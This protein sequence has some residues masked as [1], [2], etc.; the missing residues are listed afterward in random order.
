MSLGLCWLRRDL[1]LSDHRALHKASSNFDAFVVV[2]V[3]DTQIL[4]QLEN[5]QDK[6]VAFIVESLKEVD[7]TLRRQG[8]RLVVLHGDPAEE[9]PKLAKELNVQGVVAARDFE[10]YALMRDEL[11][12]ARL[13][14]QG[15]GF[16]T[17][18][19]QVI[20]E[21]GEVLTQSES[22]FRVFTPYSRRWL[23]RFDLQ[24]DTIDYAPNLN[25][26]A[27]V[28]DV[29]I[30]LDY[31]KI[32]FEYCEPWIEPGEKAGHRL[33]QEFREKIDHYGEARDFPSIE[34]GSFLSVHFR[35]GTISIREAVRMAAEHQSPGAK[36]WLTELIWREFY[37]DVLAN[38]PQVVETTFDPQY[39]KLEWQGLDEHFELWKQGQTGYP[40]IDAA[41]RCFAQTGWM[42][43][44]LRMIVA[45]FLTKDLL[46]DYRK[47]ESYF[48]AHLL[49]FDLASNNGGW[50][51]AASV[52]CDAQPYFRIFNPYS[53][54]QKFDADGTFIRQ[55]IPELADLDSKSIHCPT[56]FQVLECGYVEP[57]VEHDTQRKLALKMFESCRQR[58]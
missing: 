21:K 27:P 49:D 20:F 19:D 36:K 42:H 17:V 23:D 22:P 47:G 1:R 25:K 54:S 5:K 15:I 4:R 32:G 10:P 30:H 12:G 7:A 45:S 11:V 44:R 56:S 34:G 13:A 53:Q 29:G 8:S 50:Q 48:A 39:E 18:K 6:R 40:I 3:F 57:I 26:L 41:M 51:W 46:I 58:T 38:H 14:K 33:L 28:G 55:W 24:D 37:Q 35:F 43:N 16:Q 2:F 9:I 31:D 52:G